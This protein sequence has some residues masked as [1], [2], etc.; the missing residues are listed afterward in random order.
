MPITDRRQLLFDLQAIQACLRSVRVVSARLDLPLTAL[1]AIRL[2]EA[3]GHV[4]LSFATESRCVDQ[5]QMAA[6]LIAFCRTLSLP[7][8]KEARKELIQVGPCLALV[9]TSEV[10]FRVITGSSGEKAHEEKTYR[11]VKW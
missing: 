9:F 2:H 11:A 10:R 8:P 7:I 1:Q 6:L 4:E 3:E 5:S